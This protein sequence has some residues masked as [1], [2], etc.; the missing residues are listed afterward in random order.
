MSFITGTQME[1]L[2]AGPTPYQAAGAATVGW[3][4]A[5][6][7]VTTAQP[8]MVAA[9]GASGAVGFVQP[10]IGTDFWPST[11][12][13]GALVKI[14]TNGLISW[15]ATAGTTATFQFGFQA[16]AQGTSTA[17]PTF[18]PALISSMVIPNQTLAATNIPW[19]FELDL[20]VKQVGYGSTAVSTAILVT[21]FGGVTTAITN[22]VG[23]VPIWAPLT[24]QVVTTVDASIPNWIGATV[25]FG[26]NASASNTCTM[27]NMLVF[28]CN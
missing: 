9:T 6:G 7:A 16:A 25:T 15:V 28:G 22:A 20:L 13:A 2:F 19:R 24:P 5:A 14:I 3:V 12:G 10:K 11:K 1:T 26:T 27:L 21:G 8:L 17:A 23:V 4:Q 18:A